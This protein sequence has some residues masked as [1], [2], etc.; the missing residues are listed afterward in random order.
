MPP[1]DEVQFGLGS[2]AWRGAPTE[3][4]EPIALLAD[5]EHH[6]AVLKF[7]NDRLK[8]SREKMSQFYP[9]WRATEE[10][11]Q[12]FIG[13]EDFGQTMKAISAKKHPE[14][15]A[16]ITVP[17]IYAT[18][19]TIVTYYIH[20]F[21]GR[22]PMFQVGAHNAQSAKN[23]PNMEIML[24]HNVDARNLIRP[25]IQLLKDG[26]TYGMGV[27]ATAW[28]QDQ[29][30]RSVYK[31]VS[32]GIGGRVREVRTVFE[33]TD[34]LS[35]DPFMF[36]PDP[37]VPLT[38]VAE[39]GEF[40]FYRTF[41][42][43]HTLMQ[44]QEKNE[45]SY[46]NMAGDLPEKNESNNYGDSSRNLRADG[47]PHPG[48]HNRK[49]DNTKDYI[50]VEH[51][52]CWI[53][54]AELG[55]GEEEYPRLWKFT[56]LNGR[57]IAEAVP[58]EHD[59]PGHPFVVV[60]PESVGYGFGNLSKADY[61][62]PI[63]DTVS[64]FLNSHIWNVRA[65]LNN[66]FVVNPAMIEMKDLKSGKP[67]ALI[68]MKRSALGQDPRL[69]IQQLAVSNVTGTH[70]ASLETFMKIGDMLSAVTDNIRGAQDPGGRKTATEVRTSGEAAASR[71]AAGAKMISAQGMVPLARIMSLNYQQFLSEEYEFAVLGQDK[72]IRITPEHIVG[73]FNY[74]VHDGT[75][76]LDKVALLDVWKEI[77]MLML[78]DQQFRGQYDVGKVF[79]WIAELGGARNIQNFRL[80]IVPD[81][82]AAAAIAAG[83]GVPLG[84]R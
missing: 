16:T 17:Y 28:M 62:T 54:P 36:F 68:R 18:I 23:A 82:E 7:L 44:A 60:E 2:E 26:E 24:Q 13:L 84:Q 25:I 42:G 76:P 80:D 70:I 57:Q 3:N 34:V 48:Q 33:G 11:M 35:V 58:Y 53:I 45:L 52:T 29:Q 30:E 72:S 46:V 1:E 63:Q 77:F 50:Q 67:G 15:P 38:D 71:L 32:D 65:A 61:L 81:A 22:K 73:D 79:E 4:K 14:M 56:I 75:L 12:A 66:M 19:A 83:N 40:C 47:D 9:R 5:R 6:R 78:Q 51:G 49:S 27:L 20:T 74:P 31:K 21:T 69:A 59:H 10:R 64:W 55:L 43:R 41:Q 39:H 8:L 37:R